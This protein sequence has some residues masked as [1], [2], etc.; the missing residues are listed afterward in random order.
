MSK[1]LDLHTSLIA[2]GLTVIEASAGTGKTYSISHLVPRL[3]LE[4]TLPDVSKLLLVTFTKDAA[5][6]LSDRVRRVLTQLATPATA[7]ELSGKTAVD[8]A[9]LRWHL[10]PAQ[11]PAATE[12]RARLQRAL[13]DLDLLAVSTIHAFCQR[14]LQQEGAL[15][16]LP[17]LPEVVTNDTEYLDLIV[18]KIWINTLSADPVLAALAT[19]KKWKLDEALTVIN[20]RRRCHNPKSNPPTTPYSALISDLHSQADTLKSEEL[21]KNVSQT[22]HAVKKWSKKGPSD[23]SEALK[24]AERIRNGDTSTVTFWQDIEKVV[25]LPKNA[26]KHGAANKAAAAALGDHPWLVA[27]QSLF[28]TVKH[29]EWS[30]QHHLAEIALPELAAYMAR[31][32]LISQDGLIDT[33]HHALHRTDDAAGTEQSTRLANSLAARYHV[34]LIDESQDTDHRQFDIFKRIFLEATPLRR[35]LLVG[36]PK[37]AIYSFRGADLSTYLAA[38]DTAQARYT[39]SQT[40]RAPQPLVEVINSLFQRKGAFLNPGMEFTP[41]VSALDY[42][43]QLFR[44]GQPCSRLEVW[45]VPDADKKDYSAQIRRIPAL[46]NRVAGTIAD[47]LNHRA[48]LVKIYRDPTRKNEHTAVTP[49]HFAV[50]V[51]THKQAAGMAEALQSRGIPAVINSGADV[52]A[53]EEASDLHL[54]LHSILDPRRT[55]RLRRA[56]ATRLLGLDASALVA[57]NQADD[58]SDTT[59][60]LLDHGS[61]LKRFTYWQ[62]IWQTRGVVALFTEFDKAATESPAYTG[63]TQRLARVP[64]TGERRVTNY[65]QLTDLL[66]HAARETAPRPDELTRWL[67]QQIARVTERCEAEDRQLQLS[68]DRQAVQ[69]VTMHKAKG[70]EYPL[71]FCPYLADSLMKTK[72]YEKLPSGLFTPESKPSDVLLNLALLDEIAP[73][74]YEDQLLAAQLEERLRLAYVALTRAQ[75]RAWTCR[76]SSTKYCGS[77]FDWLLRNEQQITDY[78]AYSA[79][80]AK[81]A[82]DRDA[83]DHETTLRA[84]DA[85]PHADEPAAS[86]TFRPPSDPDNQLYQPAAADLVSDEALQPLRLPKVPNGWRVTSFSTLT[87]EKNAHGSPSAHRDKSSSQS[88]NDNEAS[89]SGT[90]HPA[91]SPAPAFLASPA[92]AL[93]GTVIHEWIETWDFSE[94]LAAS[95]ADSPLAQHI[96]SARLPKPREGQPAWPAALHDLFTTLRL[97]RLPGCDETPLHALCPDAHGSEWHFHLPLAGALTVKNLADCF[98]KHAEPEQRPYASQLAALSNDEFKGLLQ[99]FIDRLARHGDAWGVIDWKT[100]RLGTTLADYDQAALLRCAMDSHYLLQTHLYLVALRRYLRSLGLAEAPLAGAWLVFLR[101]LAPGSVRGVLHIQPSVAMLDAL[102]SLF[103][104]AAPPELAFA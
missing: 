50:L 96:N 48:E 88:L 46:S 28:E 97:I 92:G 70:L 42:D 76:Y 71:V 43:H 21:W 47:L 99:G 40:R 41:A 45:L 19:A 64:L 9:L 104:P 63:I 93:V 36:D 87:R 98:H 78:P 74:T 31:H 29:L 73:T 35:L 90:P 34:A 81:M 4:G 67:G 59:A 54:L 100:N 20:T 65:R 23:S 26:N 75:V 52:F 72:D 6:E 61:W 77:A 101:A 18:R 82:K 37:Q 69:V 79:D 13:L 10:D 91:E 56:L 30:W 32:R 14:S 49:A 94:L 80:W 66:L 86:F 60:T 27:A 57:L 12:A 103:A 3:L 89:A 53:T 33:L 24:W 68:S 84:L 51:S 15:C 38:R 22:L 39:L 83:V 85:Q 62:T 11:N 17:V 5:R 16:G 8:I 44:D 7:E 55:G 58:A 2:P 1:E 25:R 95:V 102:D